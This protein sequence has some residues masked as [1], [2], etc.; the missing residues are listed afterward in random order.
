VGETTAFQGWPPAALEWLKGIQAHNARDWFQANRDVYDQAVRE[1]F[2]AL[3]EEVAD[4]FGEGK[5]FR[6]HRDTR[7]SDD[8]RPYKTAAAAFVTRADG[9][10]GYYVQLAGDGL[11]VGGG[12]YAPARD[13]LARARAAIAAD[14]SGSRLEAIVRTLA[15]A[16][17]ALMQE[18]ALKSAPKGYPSEHRRVGLLRLVHYAAMKREPP[19]KWLHTREAKA[20]IVSTW[21][22]HRAAARMARG[23]RRPERAAAT[24]TGVSALR[25]RPGRGS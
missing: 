6:P 10:G 2:G 22:R 11:L 16:G 25:R 5:M 3:L 19:R 9:T 4:D 18:G 17:M 12:L 14:R 20:R 24:L 13:Q 15:T 7:F 23:P 1:P 21:A 8:K